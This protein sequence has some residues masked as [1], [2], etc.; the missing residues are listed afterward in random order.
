MSI[1]DPKVET[2]GREEIRQF[3]LERLQATLNR[4]YRHVSFY[5]EVFDAA[6]LLPEDVRSSEDLARVPFTSR[7]DLLVHQPYG[8]FAVPL[9]DVIRLHP[10]AGAGGP[11][12]VG[13]T[14]N[15]V[16]GWTRMAARALVSAGVTKDDV[17]QISLNYALS[18]AGVGAQ[19]GA[20]VLGASIIPCSGL[21]PERQADVMRQFRATVLIATPSQALQLGRVVRRLDPASLTLRAALIVGEVWS[22]ALRAE[23]EELLNAQAF[24]SYGLTEMAVP[25]LATECE[26]HCGL[27][28]TEDNVL[29]EIVDPAT[30]RPL[31]PG[32]IG[33]LVLTT[34]TREAVPLIRYRTGDL[35]SLHEEK[36]A[37]G[38]T[39]AR[40]RPAHRRVDDVLIVSG[41]RVSPGQIDDVVHELLPEATCRTVIDLVAGGERTVIEIPVDAEQFEDQVRLLE[42]MR[43]RLRALLA[44]RL[45]L[46]AAIRLVEPR[47]FREKPRVED[48]RA[49]RGE[50]T[51]A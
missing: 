13:Y 19:S 46:E 20:E 15:D 28:L 47:G 24:G 16:A 3:Q 21:S 26:H 25:G 14:R 30:G 39:M 27:H 35:T 11:V 6:S 40:M 32:Q 10:S 2:A 9:R 5:R 38:R 29:A 18:A 17:L 45:G 36:C 42:G 41:V 4:A 48:R 51:S 37:C 34:L 43:E 8:L 50:G 49:P 1:L 22:H 23:I 31:P 12:V 33:E 44:E 7:D